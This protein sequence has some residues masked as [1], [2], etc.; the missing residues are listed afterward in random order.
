M[1][2]Q[3]A[4]P[5]QNDLSCDG[6]DDDCDGTA[7][8]DYQAAL[9]GTGV[10]RE[11]AQ[12]SSCVGGVERLCVPGAPD[13]DDA[14]C[15][16]RDNDCDGRVDE[17]YQP[18]VACGAGA[19][20]ANP[21][22]SRCEF[23]RE[24][25]CQP[26]LPVGGDLDCNGVD[27]DCDGRTDE[28]YVEN[29][30]CGRGVCAALAIPSTCRGGVETPCQPGQPAA[31]V[32]DDCDG[33][34]SDCDGVIDDEVVRLIGGE[35]RITDHGRGAI[36]PALARSGDTYGLVWSDNRD[37]SAE[38]YYQRLDA[39]G[40]PVGAAVRLQLIGGSKLRPTIAPDGAGGF[41]V[42]WHNT[43]TGRAQVHFAR[44]GADGSI[45]VADTRLVESQANAFN[46]RLD[47]NGVDFA[48]VWSD[49]RTGTD[50]VRL[51]RL[52][53]QGVP[54]G[55]QVVVS[56]GAEPATVPTIAH[57]GADRAVAYNIDQQGDFDIVI[58]PVAADGAPQ[59]ARQIVSAGMGNSNAPTLAPSP[60]GW[61]V[62]W[63]DTR[64][65]NTEIYAA[66]AGANGARVG[67]EVRLTDDLRPSFLPALVAAG[68]GYAVAWSDRRSGNDE[69]WF[70]HLDGQLQPFGQPERLSVGPDASFGA[71]V[72]YQDGVFGIGWYDRRHGPD[73]IYFG[74]GPIGCAPP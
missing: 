37:G 41:G 47:F 2:C 33:Q 15:D 58:Q 21:Q 38:L 20:A 40:R 48:V 65:D 67:A 69:I 27:D 7:D 26:G 59:G 23:G 10:C 24:I 13:G 29:R 50:Q 68:N 9:C 64:N 70:Q 3:P 43:R 60:N 18:V 73:E 44:I 28:G 35:Q 66:L 4:P 45:L 57:R 19:C 55:D 61:A 31:P 14:D 49:Q 32:D 51:Q 42:A 54:V 1:P 63:Y 25:P 17:G 74:L 30:I 22:P 52:T 72:V 16:G 39:G 5:A 6:A 56:Q 53:A 62:A 11:G 8:E 36:Q 46:P 12:P 34:D 71:T